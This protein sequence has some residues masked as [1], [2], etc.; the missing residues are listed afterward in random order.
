MAE[1]DEHGRGS[2]WSDETTARPDH[3]R[4]ARDELGLETPTDV[5]HLLLELRATLAE[6]P[7][8]SDSEHARSLLENL[9]ERELGRPESRESAPPV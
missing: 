1:R 3:D 6:L 7:S 8:S 9:L 4:L 5:A 2:G